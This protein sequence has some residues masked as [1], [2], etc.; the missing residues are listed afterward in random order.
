MRKL[1]VLFRS[2]LPVVL[3]VAAVSLFLALGAHTRGG[4]PAAW[5]ML[6]IPATEVPYADSRTVTYSIDC[7]TRGQDPY[8]VR[9]VDPYNRLYNYPALWLDLRFLGVTSN[10]TFTFALA[11]ITMFLGALLLLFTSEGWLTAALAFAGILSRP[12]LFAVER[13]NIDM[14]VFSLMIFAFFLIEHQK[15]TVRS[16]LSGVLIAFLTALKIYPIAA[17]AVFLRNR[18]GFRTALFVGLLSVAAL[19][20]TSGRNLSRVIENTPQFSVGSYGA[21]PLFVVMSL[22]SFHSLVTLLENHHMI[23]SVGGVVIAGL[24]VFAGSVCRATVDRFFPPL[25]FD[26]A[27]G[28]IAISC[29][30]IYCFT[31]LIGSAFDY[32]LIFLLGVLA[33]LVCDLDKG[34]SLRALPA[35][36]GLLLFLWMPITRWALAGQALDGLVFVAASAWLGSTLFEHWGRT[37]GAAQQATN[38]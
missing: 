38:R 10:S 32:R 28:C 36:I 20:V 33:Y 19:L 4:L 9:T 34:A 8:T 30:A 31:F 26:S 13:G 3:G 7:L 11:L 14:A 6:R 25:D 21:F 24:S 5:R 27:R 1:V 2:R 29:L 22:H 18:K 12:P 35:S 17:V 37:E 23:A 16:F 15:Q